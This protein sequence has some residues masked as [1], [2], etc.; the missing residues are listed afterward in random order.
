MPR[1]HPYQGNH[2]KRKVEKPA[3]QS[4]RLKRLYDPYY[5]SK[6]KSMLEFEDYDDEEV[7]QRPEP[8]DLWDER[9]TE[10]KI[11]FGKRK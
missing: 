11:S 8:D 3:E 6:Q 10:E 1:P 4:D 2:R 9:R 7:P 5:Q